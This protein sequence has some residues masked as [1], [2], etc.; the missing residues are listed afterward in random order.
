M[1]NLIVLDQTVRAYVCRYRPENG[2]TFQGH[3]WWLKPTRIDRLS[4]TCTGS[5]CTSNSGAVSSR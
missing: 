4:M 1:T 5:S 2:T 3:S